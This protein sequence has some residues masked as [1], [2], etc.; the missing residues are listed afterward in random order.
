MDQ[1][2]CVGIDSMPLNETLKI[3]C[4]KIN[5]SQT[6]HEVC[7]RRMKFALRTP[8]C[9]EN[10]MW[11]KIQKDPKRSK[12]IQKDPSLELTLIERRFRREFEDLWRSKIVCLVNKFCEIIE[13]TNLKLAEKR[14]IANCDSTGE[15]LRHTGTSLGEMK[16]WATKMK[17]KAIADL[18]SVTQLVSSHRLSTIES[19]KARTC[20]S[21][22]PLSLASVESPH[23]VPLIQWVWLILTEIGSGQL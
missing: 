10:V 1:S 2:R 17:H 11:G 9:H 3:E 14:H 13:V 5:F 22:R 20:P 7:S 15:T 4:H 6:H 8:N 16:C 23:S 19:T 18:A 21:Y 12:K